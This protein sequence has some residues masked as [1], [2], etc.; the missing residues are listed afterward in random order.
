[1]A[2]KKRKTEKLTI[3][4]VTLAQVAASLMP[5]IEMPFGWKDMTPRALREEFEEAHDWTKCP[6]GS[7]ERDGF[8]ELLH[9]DARS[10]DGS[11]IVD[12]VMEEALRRAR[13]LLC[14]A[15]G[16]PSFT[17]ERWAKNIA[18]PWATQDRVF[19]VIQ[20][21]LKKATYPLTWQ[22]FTEVVL[23]NSTDDVRRLC[24]RGFVAKSE[25]G[26]EDKHKYVVW[27]SD[28]NLRDREDPKCKIL[29]DSKADFQ[30]RRRAALGFAPRLYEFYQEHGERIR[31]KI[32][33]SA[34]GTG[35]RK[36]ARLRKADDD[37]GDIV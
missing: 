33:R 16:M 8:V 35:G 20:A 7:V 21:A 6:P 32:S 34:G 28:A 11:T 29:P 15:H 31:Q 30:I 13:M 12:V 24:W 23:A 2:T 3:D 26:I 19:P 10:H 25:L 5:R 22:S 4:S 27:E 17:Q 36:S 14:R 9:S 1:M 37:R 18:E